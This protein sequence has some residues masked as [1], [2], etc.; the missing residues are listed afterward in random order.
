V[1]WAVKEEITKRHK[2]RLQMVIEMV[3]K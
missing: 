3:K 2:E 1:S